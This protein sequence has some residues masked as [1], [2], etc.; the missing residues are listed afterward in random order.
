MLSSHYKIQFVEN[1]NCP[2]L[3]LKGSNV[4]FF[5]T[6]L[7]RNSEKRLEHKKKQKNKQAKYRKMSR[8]PQ[9]N[10]II[11]TYRMWAIKMNVPLHCTYLSRDLQSI[12]HV[13]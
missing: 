6:P 10:V 11:L 2:R 1:N 12:M 13:H 5:T 8:K 4:Q 3:R 9:G 7:S